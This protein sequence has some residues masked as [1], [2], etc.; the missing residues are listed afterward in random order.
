MDQNIKENGLKIKSKVLEHIAGQMAGNFKE[1]GSTIIWMAWEF[2]HGQT[3]GAIWESIKTIKNMVMEYINGPTAD[4]I[5]DNGCAENNMDQEYIR[6]QI[7]ISNT[8]FG[9][10]E[11]VQ[12][13][14]NN[15]FQKKSAW[16]KKISDYFL[17]N[18][19]INN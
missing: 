12:N 13:G 11:N 17:E 19:K 2:I 4:Y 15:K 1:N 9:K 10:K 3:E 5:Q 16:D 6:Q 14:L 18:Q 8:D 7:L